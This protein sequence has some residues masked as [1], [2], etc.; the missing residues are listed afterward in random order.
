VIARK[1][2]I[3][4]RLQEWVIHLFQCCK[5]GLSLDQMSA[6]DPFRHHTNP[7]HEQ[8]LRRLDRAKAYLLHV[9]KYDQR[10]FTGKDATSLVDINIKIKSLNRLL[11][12]ESDVSDTDNDAVS[13]NAAEGCIAR[14]DRSG[15]L[16]TDTHLDAYISAVEMIS[17]IDLGRHDHFGA[18]M[19]IFHTIALC[20]EYLQERYGTHFT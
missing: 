4:D 3:F 6:M 8:Q 18:Q 10:R 19:S 13:A 2:V 11:S 7:F 17:K 12:R 16:A 1:S 14:L 20:V 5:T 15:N 9:K